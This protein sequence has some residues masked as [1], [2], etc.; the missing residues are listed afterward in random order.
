MRKSA[1]KPKV[2]K[3][4]RNAIRRKRELES[5]YPSH[6]FVIVPAPDGSF[7]YAVAVY[8]GGRFAYCGSN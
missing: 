2:Y 7:R 3:L 6:D 5:R 4:E 8:V 1:N